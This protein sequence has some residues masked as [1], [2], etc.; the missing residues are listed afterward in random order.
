MAMRIGTWAWLSLHARVPW[1]A[2]CIF[3]SIQQ[4][5]MAVYAP[6]TSYW[7]QGRLRPA[8]WVG[9]QTPSGHKGMPRACPDAKMT[10][11]PMTLPDRNGADRARS[12]EYSVF[13]TAQAGV[14]Q[15]Q[16]EHPNLFMQSVMG[17]MQTPGG[18]IANVQFERAG[19]QRLHPTHKSGR[20]GTLI[21][22]PHRYADVARAPSQN[23]SPGPRLT[24]RHEHQRS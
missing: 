21:T 12:A 15:G 13:C 16:K 11:I 14:H 3:G 1:G 18:S 20:A 2:P 17:S 10:S 9:R 5:R 19:Q 7:S 6:D 22:S 4:T 8:I 23:K 24:T